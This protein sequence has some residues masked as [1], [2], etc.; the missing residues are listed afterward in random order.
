MQNQLKQ[1][2]KCLIMAKLKDSIKK[3]FYQ[4]VKPIIDKVETNPYLSSTVHRLSG[5][6]PGAVYGAIKSYLYRPDFDARNEK[7][8]DEA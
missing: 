1:Q 6:I 8:Q 5:G 7:T 3:S 4:N 2:Y